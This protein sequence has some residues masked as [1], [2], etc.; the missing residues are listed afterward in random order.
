MASKKTVNAR[1]AKKPRLG[2]NFLRDSGAAL[3][4]V[5]ALGDVSS[6]TVVEIG[7]GKAV[8]TELLAQRA[9]RLIGV[10][11]DRSLAAQLR[12]QYARK[13]NVEI[14]EA[15]VLQVDLANLIRRRPGPLLA[16]APNSAD[17]PAARA[18]I[19]GN[20]PYYITSDILLH[21]FEFHQL[22][23]TIVIMVQREVA[24]RIA[25]SPGSRDYGLLSATCQ[26]Y[27]KVEKL[28]TLPPGAFSPAPKVHSAVLR[29][30]IAPRWES[31]QVSP[32][33]FFAFLKGS[34]GQKRKT[35]ANNLKEKHGRQEITGA[36]AAA[37]VRPDAR[38][39][40]LSLEQMARIFRLLQQAL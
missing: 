34:F 22:I 29:L 12:M 30:T 2:Q 35:L 40:S 10:E 33:P 9:K 32:E 6:V 26:L 3:R 1:A 7:P 11:F 24:D 36:F 21:L 27:A 20:L 13:P 18:R 23:E 25:A 5:E 17:H 4:I 31:L 16:T 19:V 39:E 38:A 8:L 15:D 28:F 14:I 37:K